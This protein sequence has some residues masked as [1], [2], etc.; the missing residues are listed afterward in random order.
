MSS[1]KKE[2][3]HRGGFLAHSGA[4]GHPQ[5]RVPREMNKDDSR[6]ARDQ[7]TISLSGSH[8]T[9]SK[10]GSSDI[11]VESTIA[12]ADPVQIDLRAIKQRVSKSAQD[13]SYQP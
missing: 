10:K 2:A 6:G 13:D 1:P 11:S 4:G 9:V 12:A 7:L 3:K 5:D 8:R